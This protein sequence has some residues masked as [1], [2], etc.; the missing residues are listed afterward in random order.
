MPMPQLP[1]PLR[2]REKLRAQGAS[3]LSDTE[4]VAILLRTGHR[5]E[6]VLQRAEVLDRLQAHPESQLI[7]SYPEALL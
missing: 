2:P 5:G 4:L 3:A 7:V 6:N 1:V